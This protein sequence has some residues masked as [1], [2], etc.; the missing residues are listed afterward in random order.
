[1]ENNLRVI[2]WGRE[3]GRL[4]WDIQ[5]NRSVFEYN[6]KFLKSGLDIAPILLNRCYISGNLRINC[7]LANQLFSAMPLHYLPQILLYLQYCTNIC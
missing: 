2:I 3:V 6:P 7:I 1:M 4:T 5:R